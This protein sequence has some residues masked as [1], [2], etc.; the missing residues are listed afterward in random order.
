MAGIRCIQLSYRKINLQL[1]PSTEE[2]TQASRKG[3]QFL[4]N[5]LYGDIAY[6]S[7]HILCRAI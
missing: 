5:K 2:L 4:V 3:A 6:D 1:K 7:E